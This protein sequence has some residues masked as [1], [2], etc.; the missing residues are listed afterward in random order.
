[1]PSNPGAGGSGGGEPKKGET[2]SSTLSSGGSAVRRTSSSKMK[3]YRAA[4]KGSF[5]ESRV[6]KKGELTYFD[7]GEKVFENQHD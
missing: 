7:L 4:K 2:R 3:V 5:Q 1:M 6:V